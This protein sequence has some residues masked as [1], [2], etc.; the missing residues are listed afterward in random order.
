MMRYLWKP[1]GRWE[2][3]YD[4]WELSSKKKAPNDLITRM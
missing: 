1:E 3:I 2:G 4:F